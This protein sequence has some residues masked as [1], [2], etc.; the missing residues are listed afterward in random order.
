MTEYGEFLPPEPRGNLVWLAVDFDG[1]IA[2]SQW[3]PDN[4]SAE[5]GTPIWDNVAKAMEAR[6]NGWKIVIHTSRAWTD[7]EVIEAW[8]RHYGIHFDKIVCGKLLAH[9]YIDDRAV[10]ADSPKWF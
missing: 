1:T 2:Q 4:P 7:Y 10:P 8:L 5:C 3:S 9:R 6:D